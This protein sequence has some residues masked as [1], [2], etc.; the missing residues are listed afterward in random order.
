MRLSGKTAI[1][2]G[3]SS[4]IGEAAARLFAAE[5]A[6]VVIGA[7]RRLVLEEVAGA[8]AEDGGSVVALAGDVRDLGRVAHDLAPGHRNAAFPQHGLGLE[9]VDV[10]GRLLL[11]TLGAR[12]G[13]L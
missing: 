10:Q 4:G 5:G 8:I 3:A 7:R 2:T 11:R 13:E 9:F 12:S 6:N 1:I